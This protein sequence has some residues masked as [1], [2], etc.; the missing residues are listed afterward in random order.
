[1]KVICDSRF[2]C[3][4]Q[5]WCGGAKPHEYD[6]SECNK[7]QFN[8]D[9]KC[10]D[11]DYTRY[12]LMQSPTVKSPSDPT[13]GYYT[14]GLRKNYPN[15]GYCS[16]DEFGILNAPYEYQTLSKELSFA[17]ADNE[18]LNNFKGSIIEKEGIKFGIVKYITRE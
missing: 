15:N 17:F 14:I 9:A 11:V 2:G 3:K 5:Y 1:M 10:I 6:L 8:K 18:S 12:V 16:C 13:F 4:E 7:C